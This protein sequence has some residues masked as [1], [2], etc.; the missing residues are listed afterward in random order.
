MKHKLLYFLLIVLI[1]IL[2]LFVIFGIKNN[3]LGYDDLSKWV[4]YRRETYKKDGDDFVDFS[5]YNDMSISIERNSIM[6]CTIFTNEC[7]TFSYKKNDN[8]YVIYT[9]DK[10]FISAGLRF[11]DDV[12]GDNPVIKVV[13]SNYEDAPDVY[14]VFYFKK[15]E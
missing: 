11:Y 3:I 10:E 12:V 8:E 4:L 7:D 14:S 6:L 9:D 1:I 15:I 13:K 5:D 2:F